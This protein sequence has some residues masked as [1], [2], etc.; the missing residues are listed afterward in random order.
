MFVPPLHSYPEALIPES[1]VSGG[2][3]LGSDEGMRVGSSR[4]DEHLVREDGRHG[5]T[6][7][8]SEDTGKKCRPEPHPD[9]GL[10][11]LQHNGWLGLRSVVCG[12]SSLS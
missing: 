3:A 4:L 1:R 2:E 11:S 6:L 9:V 10:P 12:S 5:M 8:S 7:S